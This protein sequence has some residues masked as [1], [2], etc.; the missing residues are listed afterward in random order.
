MACRG[1]HGGQIFRIGCGASSQLE[2]GKMYAQRLWKFH[3]LPE[4][5]IVEAL[6]ARRNIPT[7]YVNVAQ[8]YQNIVVKEQGQPVF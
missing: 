4:N 8:A 3:P 7:R 1:G 6:P 5:R 2:I